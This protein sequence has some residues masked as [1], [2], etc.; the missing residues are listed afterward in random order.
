MSP[1]AE[2][3][4]NDTHSASEKTVTRSSPAF[5][6]AAALQWLSTEGEPVRNPQY[7]ALSVRH[8]TTAAKLAQRV[9]AKPAHASSSDLHYYVTQQR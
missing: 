9:G 5:P 3:G 1:A 4:P 2:Q 7:L 8:V 6:S